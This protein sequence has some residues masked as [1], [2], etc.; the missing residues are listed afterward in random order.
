V[1]K[2]FDFVSHLNVTGCVYSQLAD[3][4]N[5][6]YLTRSD[7][8]GNT[9]SSRPTAKL[10]LAH[11]GPQT[12]L[13]DM[14]RSHGWDIATHGGFLTYIHHDVSGLATTVYPRSGAKIWGLLRL[15]SDVLPNTREKLF[16]LYKH[17][18]DEQDWSYMQSITDMRTILL[19]E[20]DIL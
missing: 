2:Q 19:E 5:A 12:L 1:R 8:Y 16:D 15:K 7:H 20:G 4:I 17:M 11:L 18:M 6:M 13:H 14:W 10:D 3:D 9:R